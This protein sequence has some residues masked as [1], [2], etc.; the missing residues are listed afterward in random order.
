MAVVAT[1]TRGT[2]M[3]GEGSGLWPAGVED[4]RPK[5]NIK[6]R[7]WHLYAALSTKTRLGRRICTSEGRVGVPEM[8]DS[9]SGDC[10]NSVATPATCG[11]KSDQFPLQRG[12]CFE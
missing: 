6:K 10:Q 9:N 11:A 5:E 3:S 2:V 12:Y 8:S 4:M 1:I 7:L